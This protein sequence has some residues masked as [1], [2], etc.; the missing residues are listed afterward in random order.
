MGA[1]RE[2]QKLSLPGTRAGGGLGKG[3]GATTPTD[4]GLREEA[5]TV[6]GGNGTCA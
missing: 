5:L 2:Q 1:E 6:E 3:D 4:V